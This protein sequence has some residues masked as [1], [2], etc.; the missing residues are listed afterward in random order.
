MSDDKQTKIEGSNST[1]AGNRGANEAFQKDDPL[2]NSDLWKSMH[3][4]VYYKHLVLLGL[5]R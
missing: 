4:E 3:V 1:K 2:V 5:L